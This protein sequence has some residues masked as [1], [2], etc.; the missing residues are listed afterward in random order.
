VFHF[1]EHHSQH[2]GAFA[3]GYVL[4][5]PCLLATA[6]AIEGKHARVSAWAGLAFAIK[7]QAAFF[8][9]FVILL[10]VRRRVPAGHLAYCADCVCRGH[11]AGLAGGWKASY[12]ASIYLGQVNYM[13]HVGKYFI[14]SSASL[15]TPLGFLATEV[16]L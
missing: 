3:G 2:V 7:A 4:G 11:G 5:A 1:A 9:P 6:A 12:I 14:G 13:E 8:A 16:G 15:W 10:F